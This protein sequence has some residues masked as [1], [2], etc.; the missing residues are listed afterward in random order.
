VLLGNGENGGRG[1]LSEIISLV[2]LK[3]KQEKS[4]RCGE[5]L[6][7]LP[8]CT[9]HLQ[10]APH[11]DLISL[12]KRKRG[13]GRRRLSKT[14]HMNGAQSWAV[15]L[16]NPQSSVSRLQKPLKDQK[17]EAVLKL[18]LGLDSLHS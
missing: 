5:F 11:E 14:E 13:T 2:H 7:I 1:W 9:S 18:D 16:H 6:S 4:Q 12:L 8:H 15:P 17:S 10:I 3:D